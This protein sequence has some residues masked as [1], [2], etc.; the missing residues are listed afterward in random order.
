[1]SKK[2]SAKAYL[3]EEFLEVG[4]SGALPTANNYGNL[5]LMALREENFNLY[6]YNKFI[7][8][9]EE[10][11]QLVSPEFLMSDSSDIGL[12][13]YIDH[14]ICSIYKF[15][16][17]IGD[18]CFKMGLTD[19]A[20]KSYKQAVGFQRLAS[21]ATGLPP[22]GTIDILKLTFKCKE[23]MGDIAFRG[24]YTDQASEIYRSVVTS[25]KLISD[26]EALTVIGDQQL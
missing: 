12:T 17:E 26:L 22:Q 23:K 18:A 14:Y 13:N 6:L 24:G 9:C 11:I 16:I 7:N 8:E 20:S 5:T 15:S 19:E 1:M 25:E 3:E 21:V 4:M 10:I 2:I